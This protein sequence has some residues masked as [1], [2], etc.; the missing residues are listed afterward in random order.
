[1]ACI[2]MNISKKY[3]VYM[4]YTIVSNGESLYNQ[5]RSNYT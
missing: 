3:L 4:R 5:E 1:M 2:E